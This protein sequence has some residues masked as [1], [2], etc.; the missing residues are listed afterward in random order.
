MGVGANDQINLADPSVMAKLRAAMARREGFKNWQNGLQLT[1]AN[2]FQN[3]YYLNQKRSP[4]P[5]TSKNGNT[6]D[7]KRGLASYRDNPFPS[8][9]D[10]WA[11]LSNVLMGYFN[12]TN[13]DVGNKKL[14]TIKDIVSARMPKSEGDADSYIKDIA[15]YMGV[16]ATD[17]LNLS[18]PRVMAKLRSA[19]ARREGYGGWQNGLQLE[20][21]SQ[22]QKEYYLQ[23]QQLAEARPA[24]TPSTVDNSRK[25]STH[26]GQVVVNS[27]PQSVDALTRSVE[28]QARRSSTNGTFSSANN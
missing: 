1:G 25:S 2:Q 20:G 11:A 26:I 23:Q 5:D 7:T 18:D 6:L 28:Q 27:N 24:N 9:Q 4:S 13:A 17:Q 19:I 3:E 8:E 10:G 16:A 15:S 14:R 12:G 21:G 22:Y